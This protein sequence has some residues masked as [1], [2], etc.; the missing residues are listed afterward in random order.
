MAQDSSSIPSS[1]LSIEREYHALLLRL[2]FP[3]SARRQLAEIDAFLDRIHADPI[4]HE[5]Y[6][7]EITQRIPDI[8]ARLN[9]PGID[10]STL[11]PLYEKLKELII[12]LP[13]LSGVRGFAGAMQKLHLT[14]ST[15]YGFVGEVQLGS[16]FHFNETLP[17]DMDRPADQLDALFIP[18][19]ERSLV[20]AP[21][22]LK[23]SGYL[24]RI[25]IEITGTSG[26]DHDVFHTQALVL[27]EGGGLSN[28]LTTPA[29]AARSILLETNPQFQNSFFNGYVTFD[30]LNAYHQGSSANLAIAALLTCALLRYTGARK[31]YRLNKD[32]TMTGDIR[33]NGEVL[34]VDAD[35]LKLKTEAVF[36]SD[37]NFFVVPKL[38]SPIA[39]EVVQSLRERY[40]HR[41]LAIIGLVVLSE[42]LYDRRLSRE[43]AVGPFAH[44]LRKSWRNKLQVAGGLLI[45]MLLLIVAKTTIPPVND[46]PSSAELAGENMLIKNS[47]GETLEEI[48]V[49]AAAMQRADDPNTFHSANGICKFYDIDGNGKNEFIY[50]QEAGSDSGGASTLLC[51]SLWRKYPRWQVSFQEPFSFPRNPVDPRQYLT[52]SN[53]IVGDFD[54]DGIPEVFVIAHHMFFPCEVYKLNALNGI[55]LGSFLHIGHLGLV[56]AADIAGRNTKQIFLAGWNNA[57]NSA[58]LVVLDP[59][60]VSGDSPFRGEYVPQRHSPGTE[61]YYILIPRTSLPQSMQESAVNSRPLR[62]DFN[63]L[64]KT[65]SL[66]VTDLNVNVQDS[67]EIVHGSLIFTFDSLMAVRYVNSTTTWDRAVEILREEGKAR[68]IPDAT[69]LNGAYKQSLLYW[70]GAGWEHKP[71]MNKK[72][73]EALNRLEKK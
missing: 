68:N 39:E 10:P 58:A 55:V 69:Y 5:S 64:D 63:A 43:I 38:Q 34:P 20:D 30:E 29:S 17:L 70:D 66:T 35:S 33:D 27:G 51:K 16:E 21:G 12:K 57:F 46:N 2:S 3:F 24:R 67:E 47:D 23:E 13:S 26:S 6:I 41:R 42:L 40:P 60:L 22:T 56:A 15:L 65:M 50:I 32:V 19:V 28:L 59:R 73:L 44:I 48:N 8:V 25:S 31:Q 14:L 52:I 11:R 54:T 61:M 49:G 36:F 53:F 7:L 72:Y 18:V 4:V 62:F 71:V 9:V 45:V 1:P 37:I